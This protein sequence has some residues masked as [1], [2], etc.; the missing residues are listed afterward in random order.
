M[1]LCVLTESLQLALNE[2]EQL[3]GE[4]SVIIRQRTPHAARFAKT[5]TGMEDTVTKQLTLMDK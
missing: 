2:S 4:V 3:L 5:L 1:S